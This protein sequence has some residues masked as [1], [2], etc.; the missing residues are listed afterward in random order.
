MQRLAHI[1]NIIGQHCR[2]NAAI[3]ALAVIM[4]I[5]LSLQPLLVKTFFSHEVDQTL[6]YLD[7]PG[8]NQ[9]V[10]AIGDSVGHG[11]FNGWKMAIAPLACNQ[12]TEMTGQYFFLKRFMAANKPPGAVI[13]CEL[14]PLQGNLQQRLTE[15]YV[16]RCFNRWNE[17]YQLLLVK[18]NPVFT[19]KMV[20]YKLLATYT[21]RLHLQKVLTGFSNSGIYTGLAAN[22]PP[23][24]S[25]HGVVWLLKKANLR[26]RRETIS[27]YFFKKILTELEKI[28]VP[29]YYLPP[30]VRMDNSDAAQAVDNTLAQLA[31]LKKQF[32][33][34]QILT[35]CQQQL[36]KKYFHD[37]V[38][39]NPDGLEMFRQDQ[40]RA[41]EGI[42]ARAWVRQYNLLKG[43]RR[44]GLRR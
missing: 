17:I 10:V 11:I 4:V 44:D 18:K 25:R 42:I 16:Q 40:D 2:T 5:E 3:P 6:F 28:Q 1:L 23:A 20:A 13:N 35:D 26:M 24:R 9:P 38:H 29:L 31:E 37:S 39:L 36:P 22:K 30:P 43:E 12:A 19:A 32:S 7:Q 15:N 8:K 21:Y 34:L 14:S 27:L 41:I 33:N